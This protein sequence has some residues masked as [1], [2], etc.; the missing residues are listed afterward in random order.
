[1]WFECVC[2]SCRLS[3][4][5]S[6]GQCLDEKGTKVRRWSWNGLSLIPTPLHPVFLSLNKSVG[7]RVLG[8]EQ[9]FVSFLAR[10]QQAK[11]SVGTC[12]AQ[13]KHRFLLSYQRFQLCSTGWEQNWPFVCLFKCF[14]YVASRYSFMFNYG[15]L[16]IKAKKR[17]DSSQCFKS[18]FFFFYTQDESKPVGVASAPSVLKEELFVSAAQIRIHLAFQRLHQRLRTPSHPWPPKT[19][20]APHLH[21]VSQRLLASSA[22]VMMS[23][24]DRAFIYMCLQDCLW[25][26]GNKVH[27][28]TAESKSSSTLVQMLVL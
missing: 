3:L 14:I 28:E 22:D 20:Q 4:N 23:E 5:R 16:T 10:G 12:D 17:F 8:R 1:M 27:S 19:R 25:C 11:F 6:G 9:V 18:F 21:F 13:V 15:S 24:S 2:L 26:A 7:V